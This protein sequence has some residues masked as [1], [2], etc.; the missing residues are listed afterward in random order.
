MNVGVRLVV[1]VTLWTVSLGAL[2][3]TL[4]LTTVTDYTPVIG[5]VAAPAQLEP[6]VSPPRATAGARFGIRG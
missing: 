1:G 6:I 4:C 2:L 3:G 5:S